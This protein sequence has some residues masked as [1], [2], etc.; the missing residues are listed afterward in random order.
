MKQG[1]VLEGGAM[2]GIFTCGVLDVFMENN[3]SF[4]GTIGVSAG[5]CFGVNLKSHQIGRAIRYNLNYTKD[6][7]YGSFKSVLKTGNMFD[8]DFCY[9]ELHTD[10]DIF[11]FETYAQDPMTF[12][13]VATDID[14]GKPVYHQLDTCDYDDLEWV[15]AGAA[16]PI[17]SKPVELSGHRLLDGGIAD[18]IPLSFIEEK[19]YSHNVVV[20]TQPRSYRK[21]KSNILPIIHRFYP[22]CPHLLEDME[23][24]HIR[25]N[26]KTHDIWKKA[27]AGEVFVIAP[28]EPL[29]I[30]PNESDRKELIRVYETGRITAHQ[31]LDQLKEYLKKAQD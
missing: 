9:H 27:D 8:A 1:L 18:P 13:C 17:V 15:R 30:K 3:I 23:N 26:K 31:Q 28:P 5:A 12:Y 29:N 22:D 21:E 7:R 14:T 20:L 2:R 24:R 4:D 25:Y 6:P 16:M 19:G 10:Y 11:D